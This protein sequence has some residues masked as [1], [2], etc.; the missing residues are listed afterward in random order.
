M[1]GVIMYDKCVSCGKETD[2]PRTANVDTRYHYVEGAGQ[3]C[4]ECYIRIYTE[5]VSKKLVDVMMEDHKEPMP[6]SFFVKKPE[7]GAIRKLD[8]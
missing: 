1:S 7:L 6:D 2:V 4:P 8:G 3:L 5:S